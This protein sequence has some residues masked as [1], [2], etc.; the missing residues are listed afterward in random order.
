MKRTLR[1][2]VKLCRSSVIAGIR[3]Q[4]RAR[5]CRATSC[6]PSSAGERGTD[7]RQGREGE[8]MGS[9]ATRKGRVRERGRKSGTMATPIW[10]GARIVDV[11]RALTVVLLLLSLPPGR[12]GEGAGG[13]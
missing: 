13:R 6:S 11:L 8:V 1:F 4:L 12:K 3:G 7:G 10:R 9:P 5:S 2:A